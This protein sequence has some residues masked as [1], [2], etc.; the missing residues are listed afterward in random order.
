MVK[1][2]VRNCKVEV[3]I[4]HETKLGTLNKLLTRERCHFP[5]PYGVFL[6]PKVLPEASRSYGMLEELW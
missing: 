3:I 5:N 1:E 6:P 4:F 2:V